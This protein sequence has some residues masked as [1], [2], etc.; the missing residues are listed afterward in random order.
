[1]AYCLVGVQWIIASG[2]ISLLKVFFG[3]AN[4]TLSMHPEFYWT[5][6]LHIF[7]LKRLTIPL[8]I[9]NEDT[10]RRYSLPWQGSASW[11]HICCALGLCTNFANI[12]HLHCHDGVQGTHRSIKD[13]Y[14]ECKLHGK[15]I[16][17]PFS[18][19]DYL[20][21]FS[22]KHRNQES[23]WMSIVM[24]WSWAFTFEHR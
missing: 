3:S 12:V 4:N 6:L 2:L 5:E 13:S 14:L 18:F 9:T 24:Y 16:G 8:F 11:Y 1:M 7:L 15:T 22:F 20:C 17:G 10:Y 19:L 23:L 21:T